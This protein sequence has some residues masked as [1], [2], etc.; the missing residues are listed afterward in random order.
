MSSTFADLGVP[1]FIVDALAR[2]GITAPFDIQ[3]ATI[4]DS[5]AGRDVIGRAPTGSGKTVAFGVPTVAHVAASGAAKPGR[6]KALILSPTRELAEQI[7]AEL[8]GFAGKVTVDAVYGGVGYGGQL[9]SL[10][11]G[12]DIL[13][14]CPGRLEDLIERGDVRLGDVEIVV[15]DEAD[16]MADMGFMPSVIRLLDKMP[17]RRQLLMFSATLDGEVKR[18][19]DR[20]QDDPAQHLV[21][22]ATPDISSSSH[23][24]W[25]AEREQRNPIVV[26]TVAAAWPAII[27]VRTR[28]G[29]DRLVK[30]LRR[31]GIEAEPIHGGLSQNKRTRSLAMFTDRHV[32]ALVATDVAARGIHVDGVATVIHYDPPEDSST[33]V[34]RSGR[35]GRAGAE[36]F[37]LSLVSRQQGRATKRLISELDLQADVTSPDTTE[38]PESALAGDQVLRPAPAEQRSNPQRSEKKSG[39]NGRGGRSRHN[40]QRSERTESRSGSRTNSQPRRDDRRDRDRSD[41]RSADSRD[42]NDRDRNNV[43]RSDRSRNDGG[44]NDRHRSDRSA[45]GTD[46][47]GTRSRDSRSNESGPRSS[48]S[49]DSRPGQSRSGSGQSRRDDGRRSGKPAGNTPHAAG[50]RKQRRAH[51]QPDGQR[52]GR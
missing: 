40:G 41:D 24:F 13:V 48:R 46:E 16:R 42:R 19:S 39:R 31:D 29:A 28:H 17:N 5:L 52:T 12:V 47:R 50:N 3:A 14:A 25:T 44:R 27:F 23:H 15:L 8:T 43:G 21:G 51:L 38:I 4:A 7:N 20:F 33:Y 35:T 6:P 45:R 10:Q 30:Q 26:E 37:V 2:N 34:H 36:G 22:S 49:N 11:R 1:S 9:R 18:I 32:H